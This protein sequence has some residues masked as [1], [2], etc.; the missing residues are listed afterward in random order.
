MPRS[1]AHFPSEILANIL[2]LL[3]TL[4]VYL[5]CHLSGNRLLR[6]KS[7]Q[8]GVVSLQFYDLSLGKLGLKATQ[9][10]RSLLHLSIETT[11][12][13]LNLSDLSHHL[14][15]LRITAPRPI[16]LCQRHIDDAPRL[17]PFTYAEFTAFNFKRHL[18]NLKHL[19]LRTKLLLTSS[20][21]DRTEYNKES[22]FYLLP[23]SLETLSLSGF[24]YVRPKYWKGLPP[25]LT[26]DSMY[27]TV[28]ALFISEVIKFA[29]HIRFKHLEFQGTQAQLALLSQLSIET[30]SWHLKVC[31]T[32]DL[33][34]L[35]LLFPS[36]TLPAQEVLDLR[37]SGTMPFLVAVSFNSL[38]VDKDALIDL[39]WP[40][41]LSGFSKRLG[42]SSYNMDLSVLH[43][44]PPNLA[45]MSTIISNKLSNL[46]LKLK[47]LTANITS[48]AQAPKTWPPDLTELN[49]RSVAWSSE[50]VESLPKA[51]RKLCVWSISTYTKGLFRLLP[52]SLSILQLGYPV[53]EEEL[54]DLPRSV[55]L[56]VPRRLIIQETT[57]LLSSAPSS[58]KLQKEMCFRRLC[59]GSYTLE[60]EGQSK[61]NWEDSQ[62]PTLFPVEF[63]QGSLPQHL[64]KLETSYSMANIHEN[65][66]TPLS[67][68]TELVIWS[69]TQWNWKLSTPSLT[70]L[71]VE[72]SNHTDCIPDD[73]SCPTSITR[74]D[75]AAYSWSST[76]SLLA[77]FPASLA[78]QLKTLRCDG[79][80]PCSLLRQCHALKE[81]ELQFSAS[82]YPITHDPEPQPQRV[83][84]TSLY[85]MLDDLPQLEHLYFLAVPPTMSWI[86]LFS[87]R[88][89]SL[90]C[91]HIDLSTSP[92]YF[93]TL[94]VS[95]SGTSFDLADVTI[96]QIRNDFP[97]CKLPATARIDFP[98]L[99]PRQLES[100]HT[101]WSTRA[102]T[103][104]TIGAGV[105]L[106]KHFG[107]FLPSTLKTLDLLHAAP[108]DFAAP[109]H[110][111][112]SLTDLRVDV[113]QCNYDSYLT[114]PEGLVTLTIVRIKK[115]YRLHAHM[116]PS[117]LE[118]LSMDFVQHTL[119]PIDF[120]KGLPTSIT[121]LTLG[122]RN[123]DAYV[124]GSLLP[125][126]LTSLHLIGD[127]GFQRAF[128][129]GFPP[130]VVLYRHTTGSST[131]IYHIR[132][133][134][135]VEGPSDSI[136]SLSLDADHH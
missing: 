110:L 128:I 75:I 32:D 104:I 44:M 48:S 5:V 121:D 8:G 28:D 24:A 89:S 10:F 88:L 14:I 96:A 108:L 26:I 57:R 113:S 46:P 114:F 53:D 35:K 29:P 15:T 93:K 135:I 120:M 9:D 69:W 124:S 111:P 119:I 59:D 123:V 105:K 17:S 116:L 100:L 42:G 37:T 125:P 86:K 134:T 2:Y 19:H 71:S 127:Q 136:D 66:I 92:D 109:R 65:T 4:N 99:Y 50:F 25:R 23:H 13:D 63:A 130:S 85:E 68:L 20:Y 74:L 131:G 34:S 103:S 41:S 117:K 7:Q 45:Y 3:P 70:S 30:V 106:W 76:T 21:A 94:K 91:S 56:F 16:W 95:D 40:L 80:L 97:N 87:A 11:L 112:R 83:T 27:E 129:G 132:D 90:H 51:L 47:T 52:P 78:P 81:L 54:A 60:F 38:E 126:R 61:R 58:L 102:L 67:H 36:G 62:S 1:L 6:A 84:L 49:I 133:G 12:D 31:T 72:M 55:T 118:S 79:P 77:R 122:R 82:P 101:Q 115:F 43:T 107:K 73:S 64:T 98:M 22:L 18:P 33:K 39:D